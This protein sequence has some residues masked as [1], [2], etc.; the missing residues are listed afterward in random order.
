VAGRL[1]ANGIL[2]DYGQPMPKLAMDHAL[3]APAE[4]TIDTDEAL[5]DIERQQLAKLIPHL[6]RL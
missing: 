5:R 2:N 4:L 1:D 3:P 6:N